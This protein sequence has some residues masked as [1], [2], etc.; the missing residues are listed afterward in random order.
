MI[1]AIASQQI[2]NLRSAPEPKNRPKHLRTLL[3]CA[4]VL[5]P[6]LVPAAQIPVRHKEGLVHGFLTL[7]TL[8]GETIADGDLMQNVHGERVISRLVFHFKDGSLYDDTTVFS[9]RGAFRLI[10]DHLLQKGPA[11]EHPME[12]TLHATSGQIKVRYTEEGKERNESKHLV[13]PPDLANGML[14]TLLKKHFSGN[15]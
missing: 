14:L 2:N 6:C 13:L 7:R 5:C 15:G 9:Q 11:F 8:Q 10:S 1:L 4:A 12:L 3:L